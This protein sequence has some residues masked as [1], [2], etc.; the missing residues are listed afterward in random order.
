MKILQLL[1][2]LEKATTVFYDN[3]ENAFET[4]FC[5]QDAIRQKQELLQMLE[6]LETAAAEGSLQ[7]LQLPFVWK[8]SDVLVEEADSGIDKLRTELDRIKKNA[9]LVLK[10]TNMK[11]EK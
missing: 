8:R 1:T 7:D 4:P 5:C 3:V 6:N 2:D 9:D 11:V 10:K